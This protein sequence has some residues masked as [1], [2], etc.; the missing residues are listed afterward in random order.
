MTAR[1]IRIDAEFFYLPD[2][3]TLYFNNKDNETTEAK[4]V[5]GGGTD[6]GRWEDAHEVSKLVISDSMSINNAIDRL[7]EIERGAARHSDWFLFLI[8]GLAAIGIGPFAYRARFVDL[9]ISFV[10]GIGLGVLQLKCAPSNQLYSVLFEVSAAV[11]MSFLGRMFGSIKNAQGDRIFCYAAITESAIN[12]IQPGYWITNACLE[13][14]NRQIAT[15]GARLMYA[16]VYALLLAYG[17]AIGSALY[18]IIDHDA[19]VGDQCENQIDIHWNL[20]FVPFFCIQVA[21]L[22]GAKWRQIPAMVV[23]TIASYYVFFFSLFAFRGSFTISVTLGALTM[24]VVGNL[25]ARLGARVEHSF[26]KMFSSGDHAQPDPERGTRESAGASKFGY[27]LGAAGMVPAMIVLV[28]SGLAN[29]SSLLAG[30]TT[31]NAITRNET[32]NFAVGPAAE[33]MTIAFP[34]YLNVFQ[35]SL[36]L[37][38]GLS[39]GALLIYPFGKKRSWVMSW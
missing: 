8:Y 22:G 20:F 31:A 39:L 12:L 18:G 14:M 6:L 15:S 21:I 24:G 7:D 1:A 25:Y 38:V 3:M 19:V 36:A 35:S 30:I 9:P 2:H 13:L 23:I 33:I 26:G 32:A 27:A 5:R 10:M 34:M 17:I 11:I 37:A 29:R 28:P 4:L 16:L